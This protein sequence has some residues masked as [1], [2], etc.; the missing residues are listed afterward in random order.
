MQGFTVHQELLKNGC[1]K[2]GTFC[3]SSLLNS[4]TS[5]SPFVCLFGF[6]CF[7][8]IPYCCERTEICVI[9]CSHCGSSVALLFK[10]EQ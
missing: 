2:M 1:K 8:A 5:S 9:F 7:N 6:V 3:R 10:S 4:N